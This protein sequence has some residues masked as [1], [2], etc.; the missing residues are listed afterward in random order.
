MGASV[1]FIRYRYM[2]MII[3]IDIIIERDL[4]LETLYYRERNKEKQPAGTR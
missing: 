1:S 2:Y 4:I 3:Y